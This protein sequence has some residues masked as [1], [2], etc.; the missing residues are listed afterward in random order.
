MAYV[1]TIRIQDHTHSAR[2]ILFALKN[3]RVHIHTNY[4]KN[5]HIKIYIYIHTY[6]HTHTHTYIYIYAHGNRTYV[7]MENARSNYSLT[8]GHTR[9]YTHVQNTEIDELTVIRTGYSS[10]S[11]LIFRY[12]HKNDLSKSTSCDKCAVC[13]CGCVY[14]ST[15]VYQATDT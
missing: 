9:A 10:V 13:M 7:L 2:G 8:R 3:I 4:A 6:T 1:V 14:T 11:P 12:P 5:T 15:Y